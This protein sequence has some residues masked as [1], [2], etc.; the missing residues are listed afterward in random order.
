MSFINNKLFLLSK[1]KNINVTIKNKEHKNNQNN[2]IDNNI[3]LINKKNIEILQNDFKNIDLVRIFGKGPTFKDVLKKSNNEFHI[4]INQTVN[5]LTD[6]D[7]LVI[8]D[9]HNIYLINDNVFKKI[10]YIL[11]P[12]YLHIKQSFNIDGHFKKVYDYLIKKNFVG[13]YIIYN[14]GTN[15]N[16]N[17]DYITLPSQISSCN[18]ANDFVCIFLNKF[19][20]QI[21]FYGIGIYFNKK[22]ND[23][24]VGNGIYN[25]FIINKI[26]KNLEN[27]CIKNK[28]NYKFN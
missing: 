22:Y 19:I 9:L 3:L 8:N 14:L 1:K 21:D 5:E 20:K 26:Y 18:N 28:I 13:K 4:G 12:E 27:N 10:K 2:N 7:M 24:F 15:P 6:C 17:L 23:K 11:T 16:P 25:D